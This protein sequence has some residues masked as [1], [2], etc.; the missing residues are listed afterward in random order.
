MSWYTVHVA[1]CLSTW[2]VTAFSVERFIVV[3]FPLHRAFVCTRRNTIIILLC[4]I[5]IPLLCNSYLFFVLPNEQGV[6]G[7]DG[8]HS[9]LNSSL[10]LIDTIAANFIPLIAILTLN[11]LIAFRM[12]KNA[13]KRKENQELRLHRSNS[14]GTSSNAVSRS[15]IIVST[16]FAILNIP[17][18]AIRL[19]VCFHC[20]Q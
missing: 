2:T 1:A 8:E 14:C 17:F 16:T 6:C 5:P 13:R 3:Y 4:L 18:F 20:L 15:L 11:G 12:W 9:I 19:K 7:F 10:K